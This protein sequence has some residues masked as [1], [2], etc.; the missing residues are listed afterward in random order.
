[1]GIEGATIP[2]SFKFVM[3]SKISAISPY[4]Q[5]VVQVVARTLLLVT[6]TMNTFL[7]PLLYSQ[8]IYPLKSILRSGISFL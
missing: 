5:K 1:M 3:M 4:I 7:Y 2:V 8:A 6:A